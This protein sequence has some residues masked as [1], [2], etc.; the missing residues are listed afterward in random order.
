MK[1]RERLESKYFL[2]IGAAVAFI[3][4]VL[5]NMDSSTSVNA[6]TI[7]EEIFNFLLIA[8]I[9]MIGVGARNRI[10][11]GV[12]FLNRVNSWPKIVQ[13][14]VSTTIVLVLVAFVSIPATALRQ[15]IDPSFKS[16]HLQV[17]LDAKAA[18]DKA[19]AD[20]AAADKAAADKAAADKAAADKAAADKTV[21]PKPTVSNTNAEKLG[22]FSAAHI[23]SFK[24]IVSNIKAYVTALNAGSTIRASQI[25]DLLDDNYNGSV[26]GVYSSSSMQGIQDLLDNAKDAMYMG[27]TDCTR[28][29]RKNRVDL[30]GD[31]VSEF[32]LASKYFD[33]LVLVSQVK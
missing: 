33:G 9:F 2:I 5:G 21:K 20:K 22:G 30:I 31:S 8:L 14:G 17:Q 28:G 24:T 4:L 1:I 19:A 32:V 27:V 25:C 11:G 3:S 12:K 16:A 6:P 10:L 23:R 7:V 29:F 18:A 15:A 13:L 26:R